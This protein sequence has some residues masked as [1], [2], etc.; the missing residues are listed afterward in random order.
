M[1]DS[2]RRAVLAPAV[3][4]A[5]RQRMQDRDYGEAIQ[6]IEAAIARGAGATDCLFYLKG[7]ALALQGEYAKAAEVFASV[8]KAFPQSPWQRRARFEEAAAA[9]GQGDYRAAERIYRGEAEDLFG[10]GRKQQIAGIYLEFAD[11]AFQPSD[12]L[13]EPD[14]RKAL[15]FYSPLGAGW[16][17]R[18]PEVELLA[19]RCCQ[20]WAMALR[21]SSCFARFADDHP[22]HALLVERGSAWASAN[23]HPG[24]RKLAGRG[25]LL[26]EC[27]Q[28]DSRGSPRPPSGWR[29]PGDSEPANAA[30][31]DLGVAALN[32]FWR[33]F[34][35]PLA[36]KARLL[37][38]KAAS[39][40]SVSPTPRIGCKVFSATSDWPA[41]ASARSTRTA[42]PQ[43]QRSRDSTTAGRSAPVSRG[44]SRRRTVERP[45]GGDRYGIPEGIE[46]AGRGGWRSRKSLAEFLAHHPLD[47]RCREILFLFGEML[48]TEEVRRGDRRL[49]TS[50]FE[51]PG[52]P[53]ADR[54]N[55]ASPRR[56]N[57]TWAA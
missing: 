46:R 29:K 11:A 12:P 36:S 5:I 2:Q 20:G 34:R 51:T 24:A 22:G 43:H 1:D 41:A 39:I 42:R 6:A 52:T 28:S 53:E 57:K 54:A 26:A 55:S 3:D 32:R 31:L 8:S 35:T 56:S 23:C 45:A 33:G 7:R 47:H 14:Y 16:G 38:A 44:A 50:G 27:G 13:G 18:R 49:G 9:V 21:P 4:E 15:E 25:R 19:A 40:Y 17:R 37:T 30:E 10:S 48:H